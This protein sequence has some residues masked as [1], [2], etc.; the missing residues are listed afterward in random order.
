MTNFVQ[1]IF[2]FIIFIPLVFGSL[3]LFPGRNHLVFSIISI[4]A[5]MIGS[6]ELISFFEKKDIG[7][8]FSFLTVPILG[9]T[10]PVLTLLVVNGIIPD[11]VR[12]AV[13]AG[14]AVMIFGFQI[15]RREKTNFNR[16][17]TS[18]AAN[19]T[20]LFYPGFFLAHIIKMTALPS[21]SI[22]ITVFLISVFLNDTMA[23]T[24]GKLFGKHS[25]KPIP[26][27]PNKSLIGF[28]AGMTAS[29]A[30][31]AAGA[32]LFPD[33]FPGS[34]AKAVLLGL[35]S[36]AGVISGD[37]VESAMKRAMRIKDSGVVIP[38]RGGI[39]DSVDSP[40][41]SSVFFYYFFIV[42]YLL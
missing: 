25:P 2:A 12:D 31:V 18:I 37:L 34:P 16:C 4:T 23:Y 33:A 15:T 5:G 29:I 35:I 9:I 24:A 19:L 1:R 21:S 26:L 7:S 20:L 27:S 22:V 8:R 10:Y 39:L 28:I 32:A 42:L 17:L 6:L 38:G 11:M 3:L 14:T 41:F 36:G 30:V 13:I 40:V